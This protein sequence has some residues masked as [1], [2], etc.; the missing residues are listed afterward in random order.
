MDL[1][2]ATGS[3]CLYVADGVA[4]V[5]R[6]GDVARYTLLSSSCIPSRHLRREA[7]SHAPTSPELNTPHAQRLLSN[8]SLRRH[9]INPCA[10]Q[11]CRGQV[12]IK[13]RLTL[14]PRRYIIA[15][16]SK[17]LLAA[18]RRVRVDTLS[19]FLPRTWVRPQVRHGWPLW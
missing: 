15:S 2:W 3:W 12:R 10:S 18:M 19:R 8:L 9:P 5:G 4:G 1:R 6:D 16:V 14:L 13:C 11:A 7:L 17:G